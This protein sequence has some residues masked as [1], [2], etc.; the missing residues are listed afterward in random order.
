LGRAEAP[1]SELGSG[2]KAFPNRAIEFVGTLCDVAVSHSPLV[3][4]YKAFLAAALEALV[5]PGQGNAVV[6]DP[7]LIQ[8]AVDGGPQ[9]G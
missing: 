9:S 7:P 6:V 2:I 8:Y 4:D 3:E 5:L 1:S